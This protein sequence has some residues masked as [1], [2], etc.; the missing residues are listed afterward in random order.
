MKK[1]RY[2][3]AVTLLL[4]LVSAGY[5]LSSHPGK[6]GVQPQRS[7]GSNSRSEDRWTKVLAAMPSLEAGLLDGGEKPFNGSGVNLFRSLQA[8]LPK[9]VQVA[10]PSPPPPPVPEVETGP[11]E[12]PLPR[13]VN[14]DYLGQV[15]V[16]GTKKV[17]L[18]HE[19]EVFILG[20]GETFGP[21]GQFH[22]VAIHPERV[23][24][25]RE[26]SDAVIN[27]SF[28]D[29]GSRLMARSGPGR[30]PLP[31]LPVADG[32]YEFPEPM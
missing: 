7:S 23:L 31:S 9:P 15:E 20:K 12:V 3:I 25:R 24:L 14:F 8:S 32:P 18:R 6:Q 22:L 17:F 21:Q 19:E 10:R 2:F 11:R 26:D 28:A 1:R 16:N 29:G 4:S 30:I 5:S 13:P 27:L